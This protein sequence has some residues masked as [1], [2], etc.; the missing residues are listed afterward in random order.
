MFRMGSLERFVV[1]PVLAI[2]AI[3]F[4]FRETQA[5]DAL[6]DTEME[7][8]VAGLFDIETTANITNNANATSTSGAGGQ[9]C[10]TTLGGGFCLPIYNGFNPTGG[11]GD[12]IAATQGGTATQDNRNQSTNN[13]SFMGTTVNPS[14]SATGHGNSGD[15]LVASDGG[16]ITVANSLVISD[17]AQQNVR[18]LLLVNSDSPVGTGINLVAT[19]NTSGGGALLGLN[20]GVV[21]TDQAV[22]NFSNFIPAARTATSTGAAVGQASL[23]RTAGFVTK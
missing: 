13:L 8:V 5:A 10:S 20:T 16:T 4:A 23:V 6:S 3:G 11:E 17:Q 9:S 19:V 22:V 2:L 7:N 15:N 14:W 1:I 12:L 18:A 21:T